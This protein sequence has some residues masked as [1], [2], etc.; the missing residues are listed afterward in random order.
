MKM[1]SEPRMRTYFS[2]LEG[3]IHEAQEQG[4]IR[5][6]VDARLTAKLLFG[7]LDE[8]VTNWLLSQRNYALVDMAGPM[9][10]I[11]LNGIVEK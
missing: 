9:L 1:F 5:E 3:I 11:L 7:S 2:I 8:L 4:Q 6:D 10:D